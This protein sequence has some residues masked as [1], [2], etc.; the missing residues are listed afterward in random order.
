MEDT[1]DQYVIANRNATTT[2]HNSRKEAVKQR[3]AAKGNAVS[4]N[5]K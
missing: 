1:I 5:K 4:T 2:S 3:I